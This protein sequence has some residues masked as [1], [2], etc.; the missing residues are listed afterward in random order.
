MDLKK[1]LTFEEQLDKLV[2]HGIVITDKEKAID[3]LKKV[4]YY[5]FTG[6]A[7]LLRTSQHDLQPT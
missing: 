4:N 3:I 1:P 5:R 2:T 6:Y 7:L